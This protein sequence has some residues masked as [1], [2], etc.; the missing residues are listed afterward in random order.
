MLESFKLMVTVKINLM[1][2]FNEKVLTF[3][4][5]DWQKTSCQ[6]VPHARHMRKSAAQTENKQK[7]I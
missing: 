4:I 7:C 2:P 1:V 3:P 5:L 6:L